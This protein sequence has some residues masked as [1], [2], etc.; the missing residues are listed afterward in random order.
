MKRITKIWTEKTPEIKKKTRVA[1]CCRVS[2]GSDEQLISLE[3]HKAHY[4]S[5]IRLNDE[6]E[7]AGLYNEK[8]IKELIHKSTLYITKSA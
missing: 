2:T 1:A 5:F 4:E 3:T 7:F 8:K 6:W